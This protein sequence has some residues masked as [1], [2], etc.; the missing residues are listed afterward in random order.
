[1]YWTMDWTDNIVSHISTI[2]D[3][4][5]VFNTSRLTKS[6]VKVTRSP[7]RCLSLAYNN[8]DLS[9][10]RVCID[11]ITKRTGNYSCPTA[12]IVTE[13]NNGMVWYTRV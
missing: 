2:N 4:A 9:L 8:A 3:S 12:I 7:Y 5:E 13:K 6:K 11:A 1:M 10:I